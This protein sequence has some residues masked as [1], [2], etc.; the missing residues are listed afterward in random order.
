M[1]SY[2]PNSSRN[3]DLAEPGAEFAA[4][5]FF[6]LPEDAELGAVRE[7][8]PEDEF[9]IGLEAAATEV[10]V[11]AHSRVQVVIGV[12]LDFDLHTTPGI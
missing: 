11:F 4:A 5:H 7:R 9:A 3:K 6:V 2:S 8:R 10:V 1:E 12:I